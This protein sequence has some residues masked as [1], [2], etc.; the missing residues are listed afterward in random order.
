[1]KEARRL[2]GSRLVSAAMEKESLGKGVVT[3]EDELLQDSDLI[4]FNQYIGWYDGAAEKCGKVSWTFPVDKPVVITEWGA[5][6]KYG[7]HGGADVK[8]TEEY[9]VEVYKAQ[10]AMQKKMPQLAGTC[11]WIMK[12]FRSPRRHHRHQSNLRHYRNGFFRL[13]V[14]CDIQREPQLSGFCRGGFRS[15]RPCAI[16]FRRPRQGD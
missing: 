5:G 1:V 16:P 9:G 15:H 14:R 6:V 3:V 7:Y 2:D 8:F 11:P 4:S 10:I 13:A 12:D